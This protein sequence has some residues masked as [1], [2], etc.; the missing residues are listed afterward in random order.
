MRQYL[1]EGLSGAIPFL[2]DRSKPFV[3]ESLPTGGTLTRIP[4]RFSVCDSV[5]GNKRRYRKK[6]WENNLREGSILQ[7]SIKA[8]GAFGLLEHPKDG[9]VTLESPISHQVTKAELIETRGPDGKPVFEVIGE[10]SIYNPNLIPEAAKLMG[11][12][13]GGYN[14]MVSSRGYGSLIKAADGIDDVDDDYVCE[15]WDVVIKPSFETA[16]LNP[17]RSSTVAHVA[18][19]VSPNPQAES[20]KPADAGKINLKESSPSTGLSKPTSESKQKPMELNE[21]KL[22]IESLRNIDP[23]QKPARVAESLT[24]VDQL[25]REVA[26]WA[27]SDAKRSW[28]AHQLHATLES[29]TKENSA[30]IRRPA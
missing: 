15:G 24:Q 7:E 28:D 25:H 8:H 10:I 6:V 30:V 5:N 20:I 11:L 2:V 22:R 4:G 1:A 23:A 16:I 14:P 9:I 18:P 13:E 21:I 3:S 17:D 19:A 26:E 29:I 12:I 27:A